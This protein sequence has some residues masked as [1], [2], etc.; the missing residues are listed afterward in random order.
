MNPIP[1]CHALIL[2]W[3][4]VMGAGVRAPGGWVHKQRTLS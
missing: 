3:L 1:P 4:Q 2:P